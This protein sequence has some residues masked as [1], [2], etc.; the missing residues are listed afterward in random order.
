[1]EVDK[2][3]KA[4][5]SVDIIKGDSKAVSELERYVWYGI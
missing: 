5:G 2:I 1:M 3:S 4:P